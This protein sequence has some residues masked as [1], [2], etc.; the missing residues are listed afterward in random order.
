M[1]AFYFDGRQSL[2]S[3]LVHIHRCIKVA[4]ILHVQ[5][6]QGSVSVSAVLKCQ[7]YQCF[8]IY[9]VSVENSNVYNEDCCNQSNGRQTGKKECLMMFIQCDQ[10]GLVM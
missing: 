6:L 1:V 2:T 9:S 5:Y 4:L 7:F 10:F 8:N 3:L